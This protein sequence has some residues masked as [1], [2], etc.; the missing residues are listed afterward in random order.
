MSRFDMSGSSPIV[1]H[2]SQQCKAA[3]FFTGGQLSVWPSGDTFF[4]T[5][6]GVDGAGRRVLEDSLF[7]IYCASKPL[8][9]LLIARLEHQGAIQIDREVGTFIPEAPPRLAAV[10]LCDLL[11]HAACLIKP[12]GI[13]GILARAMMPDQLLNLIDPGPGH[14]RQELSGYSE[15]AAWYVLG[16][17][18]RRVTGETVGSLIEREVVGPLG[19]GGEIFT[20]L[21]VMSSKAISRIRTNIA[22][23]EDRRTDA[24]FEESHLFREYAGDGFCALASMRG[25]CHLYQQLLAIHA[26]VSD[27]SVLDAA[28]FRLL[29]TPLDERYD[30]LLRRQCTFGLGFMTKLEGHYFGPYL[31]ETAFGNVGL[32]GMTVGLA[33]PSRNL[34]IA[35]HTNGMI[36]NDPSIGERRKQVMAILRESLPIE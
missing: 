36:R 25:L 19:L 20:D 9:A 34:A 14:N 15:F 13:E 21:T 23:G 12:L 3:E 1:A 5:A 28:S 2:F 7:G 17:V 32:M 30:L 11:S 22:L 16:E 33:D 29:V 10:R 24:V 4:D 27:S 26:G 31:S 8:L 6:F 35:W 18:V